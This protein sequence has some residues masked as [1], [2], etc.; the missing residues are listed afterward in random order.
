MA[1]LAS[2]CLVPITLSMIGAWRCASRSAL[3][4]DHHAD[5]QLGMC[6][7]HCRVRPYAHP[8]IALCR[9]SS[10]SVHSAAG[11]NSGKKT[12][13]REQRVQACMCCSSTMR[14]HVVAVYLAGLPLKNAD[15]SKK[16]L[17]HAHK[18]REGALLQQVQRLVRCLC[19][20]RTVR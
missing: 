7:L 17:A 12:H 8:H 14:C 11:Q 13:L 15:I 18:G 2:P 1:I 16:Q 10:L 4:R 3:A 5:A 6:M 19:H 20:L 9:T